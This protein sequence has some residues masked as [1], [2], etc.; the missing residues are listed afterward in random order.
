MCFVLILS[1]SN[2]EFAQSSTIL[3][4]KGG[5][6]KEGI[7]L[8]IFKKIGDLPSFFWVEMGQ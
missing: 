3:T 1:F 8:H 7:I 4:Y 5:P 2:I 6:K